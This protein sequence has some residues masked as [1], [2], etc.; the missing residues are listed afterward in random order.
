METIKLTYKVIANDN[1]CF[2]KTV[3]ATVANNSSAFSR[4]EEIVRK[5]LGYNVKFN[6][7]G[8]QVIILE[9]RL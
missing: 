4:F 6:H 7:P 9:N 3:S 1:P 8:K 2:Q 5:K